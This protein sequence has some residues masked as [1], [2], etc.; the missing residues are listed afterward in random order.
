M[1]LPF[2]RKGDVWENT[3]NKTKTSKNDILTTVRKLIKPL[4][5]IHRRGLVHL[6]VKLEN[7]VENNSNNYIM[8]D[9]E[10]ARWFTKDYYDQVGLGERVGTS[11]YMAPE[12]HKLRC[13]SY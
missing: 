3:F 8:I 7:Y 1:V 2:Y 11:H 9:F 12:I 4:T 10:H 5:Y 6:D 13:G